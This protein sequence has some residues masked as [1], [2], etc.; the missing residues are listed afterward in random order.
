VKWSYL[1]ETNQPYSQ[2]VL[3]DAAHGGNRLTPRGVRVLQPQFDALGQRLA[4]VRLTNGVDEIAVAPLVRWRGSW[5][6]GRRVV[7]ARGKVAQPAF[8]PDGRW[9]SYLAADGDG[10]ALYLAPVSGGRPVRLTELGNGLDA[11]S[12]PIWTR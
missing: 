12:H 10:F 11:R 6:L 4:F 2:L 8:T 9:I 7:I 5:Q 1:Q 3:Y